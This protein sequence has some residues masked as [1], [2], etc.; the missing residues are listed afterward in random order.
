M[1]PSL[2]DRNYGDAGVVSGRKG[3]LPEL[4][5]QLTRTQS[6]EWVP[7]NQVPLTEA[8]QVSQLEVL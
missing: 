5:D 2:R 7:V 4:M 8:V 1:P 6:P 3:R